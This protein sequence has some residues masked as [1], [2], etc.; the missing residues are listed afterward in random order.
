MSGLDAFGTELRR[1]DG[2]DPESFTAIAHVTN[3][4]GP[5]LT[6]V[7][8]DTTAHDTTDQWQTFIGGLKNAG[9]LTMTLRYDPT[10]HDTLTDDLGDKDPINYELAFPTSPETVWDVALVMTGFS[11]GAPHDGLATAEVTF[12]ASGVP[13]IG[14]S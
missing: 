12:Q 3:I 10:Q 7:A 4:Q 2:G 9:E 13:T 8:L 1:G 11:P 14:S 5:G 6:R